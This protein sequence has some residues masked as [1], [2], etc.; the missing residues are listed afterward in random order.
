MSIHADAAAALL[1]KLGDILRLTFPAMHAAAAS[2]SR[3]RVLYDVQTSS[4]SA[5][6]TMI[7]GMASATFIYLLL[8][9]LFIIYIK[10]RWWNEMILPRSFLGDKLAVPFRMD[11]V[12]AR[13]R[14]SANSVCFVFIPLADE[15]ATASA[16]CADHALHGFPGQLYNADA[17]QGASNSRYTA[18]CMA[19]GADRS[20]ALLLSLQRAA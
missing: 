10:W 1:G 12:C 13:A 16:R 14:E 2:S 20:D 15:G 11:K 7:M 17:A 4:Q 9:I 8:F 6:I 5:W 19:M 3:G 18:Q